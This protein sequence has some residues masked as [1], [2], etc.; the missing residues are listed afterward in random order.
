MKRL[1]FGAD[2]YPEHWERER[3]EVDARL[4]QQMGIQMVRMAEFSWHKLQPQEDVFDFQWLDEAIALL[5]DYGIYTILGTPTAAPPAWLIQKHPEILPID[6]EGRVRGF[7]GRHHDCQS[8]PIY[9]EAIRRLVTE[10]AKHYGEN[11]WDGPLALTDMLDMG[12][13]PG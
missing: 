4:M 3:W 8:N 6:R 5:A 7:G 1:H 2:Y 9:R 10:M 13:I 12:K 11:P